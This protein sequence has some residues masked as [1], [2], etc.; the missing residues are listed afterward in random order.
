M[1][2]TVAKEKLAA[3]QN[4]GQKKIFEKIDYSK[5]FWK[6]KAGKYQIRILPSKFNKAWPFREVYFHYGFAKGPI[7]SLINWGEIDPIVDF[8]K[9]LRQSSDREDWKLAK[10]FEPKLRYFAPVIVR[11]EEDKGTRLWEFGKLVHDQLLAIANDEDYGDFTN[12]NEGRDFTIS[13]SDEVI[14]G[15]NRVKCII[16]I[17]PKTS[18]VSSNAELVSKLLDEQPDILSINR[19]YTFDQLKDVLTKYLEPKAEATEFKDSFQK[20]MNEPVVYTPAKGKLSKGDE[21]D[22]LFN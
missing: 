11:G 19:K 3:A 4:K 12:I 9:K 5:I 21:F 13:A 6:P 20:E 17:K 8:A 15:E 18:T 10:T 14:A 16:Q 1:D 2:L 22:E 7:L